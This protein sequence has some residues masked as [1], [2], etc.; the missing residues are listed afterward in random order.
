MKPG[1]SSSRWW[2]AARFAV[3][4]GLAVAFHAYAYS[5]LNDQR[6]RM[7]QRGFNTGRLEV[8][9]R[10][11]N[12]FHRVTGAARRYV[13]GTAEQSEVKLELDIFWSRIGAGI[14]EA[15]SRI[16]EGQ[17]VDIAV[18]DQLKVVLP[19]M[20]D[21]VAQL[22]T[23]D[24]ASLGPLNAIEEKVRVPL[25][26]FADASYA[27]RVKSLQ[28]TAVAHWQLFGTLKRYQMAFTGYGVALLVLL[29]GE[30]L[31]ADRIVRRLRSTSESNK[32]LAE[33][34]NLTGLFNRHSFDRQL[35]RELW[36][37]DAKLTTISLDIDRFH[38][39]ND[40]LGHGAADR[41][42]V[43]I[44]RRVRETAGSDVFTARMSSDEFVL[45]TN[46]QSIDEVRVLAQR[47]QKAAT[48]PADLGDR[49][50]HPSVSMAIC[51][52]PLGSDKKDIVQEI[53]ATMQAAKSAGGGAIVE[54]QPEFMK[55]LRER[56]IIEADLAAAIAASE[57][58]IVAQPKFALADR[59]VVGYEALVR[60][61]HPT[62]GFVSPELF[63]KIADSIGLSAALGL[64]VADLAFELAANL[65]RA[66]FGGRMSIN[67]S[68]AFGSHPTFVGDLLRVLARHGLAPNEVELE[69]TEEAMMS[70]SDMAHANLTELRRLGMHIAIDD[71]GKG[72]SNISR[73]S[74]FA[75]SVIKVDKS[76]MDQTS[77]DKSA[78]AIIG[79]L[80]QLC[81]KL[82]LELIV[83]GV[84]TEEQAK[85]L[86]SLN[87]RKA[88]GY[89]F[90]RPMAP[91]ALIA[92]L[93]ARS[94]RLLQV[95]SS[96]VA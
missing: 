81:A 87:V 10:L 40:S 79:A 28:E 51:E 2:L 8:L 15:R 80:A 78:S 91:L 32:Q 67:V 73:L 17:K 38:S 84:E 55:T 22:R 77:S 50:Y 20:D 63:C 90:A 33:L 46:R 64:K 34:D 25:A 59:S 43:E 12:E 94:S 35:Q 1:I 75:A 53:N 11:E 82:G 27:A 65:K 44:A 24:P 68:P 69:V 88:Q 92:W 48:Q 45:L 72:H 49:F 86:E 95:A 7:A 37:D 14:T 19:A 36:H 96:N 70:E 4:I 5:D 21:A 71:F 57:I 26:E 85:L 39:V 58:H 93:E 60:W 9:S 42:L 56:A 66:Q 54:F 76:L 89:L 61:N 18:L 83:E 13:A 47:L 29:L 3:I 41:L 31:W 74:R 30:L 62:L 52:H 6:E 23:G 16:Y